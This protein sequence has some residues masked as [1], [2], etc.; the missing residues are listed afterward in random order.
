MTVLR[1]AALTVV[2]LTATSAYA[3]TAQ[4]H[5]AHHPET[6]GAST[7][8]PSAPQSGDTM[9][10]GSRG[11]RMMEGMGPSAM[12]GGGPQGS[13][14]MMGPGGMMGGDMMDHMRHMMG[15]MNM[16]GAGMRPGASH[17][18]GRLAFLKTE[19]K[20]ADAQAPQWNAFAET[21]RA[22]A[23]SMAEAHQSTMSD[24]AAQTLPERLALEEKALSAHLDALK[25]TAGALD[26]VYDTL[27]VD[28]KK[29]A[30]DIIVG[31]MGMPVGMM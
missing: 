19:L 10:S 3:Q 26:K 18:E 15:M 9:Q 23:K 4:D 16:M 30:D 24:G 1:A 12:M 14:M 27:S 5:E 6:S 22:N 7:S 20:I 17:I 28:Q 2:L 25:R 11:A 21:V 29:I 13:G 8:V 31:P